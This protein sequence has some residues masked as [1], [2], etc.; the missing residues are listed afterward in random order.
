MQLALSL[1]EGVEA[2]LLAEVTQLPVE[3]GAGLPQ[4]TTTGRQLIGTQ[5]E[6]RLFGRVPRWQR[7]HCSLG[8]NNGRVRPARPRRST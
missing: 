4:W 5:R 2:G 1:V 6:C 3:V 8:P 7:L